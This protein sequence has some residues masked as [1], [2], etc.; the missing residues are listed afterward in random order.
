MRLYFDY[1]LKLQKPGKANL[2]KKRQLHCR[3][4]CSHCHKCPKKTDFTTFTDGE[5]TIP[6]TAT[7]ARK[8]GQ[9][10]RAKNEKTLTNKRAKTQ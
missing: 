6:K 2:K 8:H 5:L 4:F 10:K 3:N 9:R 7:C 1:N